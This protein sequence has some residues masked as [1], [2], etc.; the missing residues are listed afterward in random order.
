[1]KM[2]YGLNSHDK[3]IYHYTKAET[4][5]DYILK[6]R[7]LRLSTLG[8][9]NDPRESKDWDFNLWTAGQHDLGGYDM[10]K[11][12]AWLSTALKSS[13]RLAC[14]SRDRAP[15]SGDHTLDILNRGF[16]RSRMW[17]Q[18]ADRHRGVCLVFDRDLLLASVALY[19]APRHICLAGDVAY[20][21]HYIVR[22]IARHEFMIDVDELEALGTDAYIQSHIQR[23]H[24]ELFFEKLSDWRDEIEWRLLVWGADEGPLFLPIENSLVGVVHA[25]SIDPTISDEL[26]V[27]T[28]DKVEH[29][30]LIWKNSGPWY[31]IGKT[32]WSASDRALLK[33]K[34]A[35]RTSPFVAR[36]SRMVNLVTRQAR[37]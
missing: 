19:L 34:P 27:V 13:A 7:T 17:A 29:M 21:D 28:G 30:G 15:L 10:V 25:A 8:D 16:A 37:R 14:F 2:I 35:S 22:D 23:Y 20:K 24:D 6:S 32:R 26:I 4:A 3:Y 1:M 36:I 12:S 11:S 31:D 9:T 18:Y 5:R 33:W